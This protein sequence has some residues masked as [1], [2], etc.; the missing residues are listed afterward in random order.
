MNEQISCEKCRKNKSFERLCN[1]CRVEEER[2]IIKNLSNDEVDKKVNEI[3]KDIENDS[4]DYDAFMSLFTIRRIN[5][6]RIAKVAFDTK[7]YWPEELYVDADENVRDGLI[8]LLS[9]QKYDKTIVDNVLL[10]LSVIGDDVVKKQFYK[11][12]KEPMPWRKLLYVGTQSYAEGG[13]FT[14]DEDG[15]VIKLVFDKCYT[16]IK[17]DS[18]KAPVKIGQIRK[19]LCPICGLPLVDI[20]TI[21]GSD[22]R[23]KYLG[24]DGTVSATVCVNCVGF[25]D[26]YSKYVLNGE[27]HLIGDY[28]NG[29][30]CYIELDELEGIVSNKY[31]L[32]EEVHSYYGVYGGINTI[33]GF[34]DFAQDFKYL[35]CPV[36]GEKM[37]YLSQIH[38]DTILEDIEGTIYMNICTDCKI[39]GSFHQ[40]T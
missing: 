2:N 18:K 16:L 8:E 27:S 11:W 36:C 1:D 9:N 40:Q 28:K 22:D 34:A 35:D 15:N 20:I 37:K 30:N 13:G 6:K 12:H 7:N 38:W 39:I 10:C 25:E 17:G 21:D 31:S 26:M 5:T 33:G 24:I 23:L 32:G 19:D 3:I 4:L 14:F 29:E